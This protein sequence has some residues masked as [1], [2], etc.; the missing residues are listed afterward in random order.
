[1]GS[2]WTAFYN[3]MTPG[4]WTPL[5]PA[6]SLKAITEQ[7]A[8]AKR[9]DASRPPRRRPCLALQRHAGPHGLAGRGSGTLGLLRALR[10]ESDHGRR[11]AAGHAMVTLDAGNKDCAATEE[12]YI[13]D[14][15]YDAAASCSSIC[16]GR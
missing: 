8:R 6:A 11:Q 1:M 2:V 4:W 9:I 14:C 15:D 5:P 12:P 3:C 16:S 7:L 10:R 13:N